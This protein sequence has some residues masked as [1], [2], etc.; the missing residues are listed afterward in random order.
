MSERLKALLSPLN[1]A[2]LIVLG[3]IFWELLDDPEILVYSGFRA[4]GLLL[5]ALLAAFTALFLLQAA[6]GPSSWR[7][8]SLVLIQAALALALMLMASERALSIL[9]ILVA[10]Q[11]VRHW[12]PAM[13]LLAALVLNALLYG[14]Y[15]ALWQLSAP[16]VS[17]LGNG[18]F[19]LFAGITAWYAITAVRNRDQL[20][21]VNSDLLATRSLLA[22]T[23][24]D[25]ERLRLSR[26]LH[27]VAGHKL[28]ALKLNLAAVVRNPRWAGE[29]QLVLCA[30]LADE[31]LADIRGV[32]QQMRRD[33]GIDL[34]QAVS[35]LA[36]PFPRPQ[37]QV[38]I[39]ANARANTIEQAEA[40]LR[41]VQEAITN[42]ARH[43]H[44]QHLWVVLRR[45]GDTLQLDIRDDGRGH[46]PLIAGNGLVGMRERLEALDGGMRI[47]RSDTGGVRLQAWLPVSA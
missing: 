14:V 10:A 3:A 22:E 34:S 30:R 4:P 33:E 39:A 31:L 18:S 5:V 28:T 17:T 37:V 45:D 24:R 40:V 15:A 8:R 27:D 47:E 19:Q 35:N 42:A 43:S 32:V 23:A 36:A 7:A 6:A 20:A 41:T 46:G 13:A 29:T 1:L 2:G 16:L 44:A 21:A 9:W 11:A 12:S 38:E 25:A 26:E